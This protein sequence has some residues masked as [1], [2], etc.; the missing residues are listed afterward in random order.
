MPRF[1]RLA[2]A[3]VTPRGV[4]GLVAVVFALVGQ[5]AGAEILTP[6]S[7]G[8]GL[9]SSSMEAQVR[10]AARNCGSPLSPSPPRCSS[11]QP[12]PFPQEL[13][14]SAA[15]GGTEPRLTV[16]ATSRGVSTL[17]AAPLPPTH[18]ANCFPTSSGALVQNLRRGQVAYR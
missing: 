13:P 3:L 12:R 9:W 7:P 5:R 1:L 2:L 10:R 14:P 6:S 16:P 17:G 11:W 8:S 4:L 18:H 15:A